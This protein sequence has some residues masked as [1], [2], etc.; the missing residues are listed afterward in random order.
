MKTDNCKWC[1]EHDGELRLYPENVGL[2]ANS[3]LFAERGICN[4]N[5]GFLQRHTIVKIGMIPPE[6][7]CCEMVLDDPK[8]FVR[9]VRENGCYVTEVR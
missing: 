1:Q 8:A 4:E 6:Y 7:V 5:R 9:I 3:M 2:S